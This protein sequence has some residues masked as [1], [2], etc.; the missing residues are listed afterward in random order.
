VS[1]LV[2][3]DLQ[4]VFAD[5]ESPWGSSEFARAAE[6]TRRLLPVFGER[7]VTTRFVAPEQPAG[8]WI[9]Y[10]RHWPFALVP[11][12]DRLYGLV[13]GFEGHRTI[14]A[15][16]FGKWGPALEA[17]LD[18]SRELVLTGVSTDCCVLSTALAA[19]DAGVHVRVVA[20]A[21]AGAS[22]D[23]H[24]RALDAMALYAPLIELTTVEAVLEERDRALPS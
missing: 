20:D 22:E 3:I 1:L 5:A 15:T 24:R 8:A 21:C 12:S 23:D 10:Y 14:T 13:P 17:E 9:P 4:H 2:A 18:G 19:A 11:A 6:G 16:T 7:V